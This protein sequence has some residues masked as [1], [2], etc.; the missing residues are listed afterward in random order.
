[1][2]KPVSSHNSYLSLTALGRHSSHAHHSLQLRQTCSPSKCKISGLQTLFPSTPMAR[3]KPPSINPK[4][5]KK[6]LPT[7]KLQE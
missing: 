2:G 4:Y 6:Y 3:I 7:N 5:L 1:M